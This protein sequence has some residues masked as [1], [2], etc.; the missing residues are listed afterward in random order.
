MGKFLGPAPQRD[1]GLEKAAGTAAGPAQP[2]REAEQQTKARRARQHG[3]TWHV[4]TGGVSEAIRKA[5]SSR[6]WH[7]SVLLG[8]GRLDCV[9]HTSR[10]ATHFRP[11]LR[12]LTVT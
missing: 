3:V 2:Q 1:E 12:T 6:P 8:H 7:R 11:T 9:F 4:D 10:T 5:R